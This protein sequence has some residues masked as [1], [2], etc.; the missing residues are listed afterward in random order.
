M[1]LFDIHNLNLNFQ[2]GW[3]GEDDDMEARLSGE[4]IGFERPSMKIA[5]FTMIK[6]ASRFKNPQRRKLL[7]QAKTRYQKDGLNSVE[8]KLK[9]IIDY[10]YYTHLFIDVGDPPEYILKLLNPKKIED[11]STTTYSNIQTPKYL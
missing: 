9:N 6:H 3:G 4:K 8:Y 7:K 2:K 10:K 1:T 5:R 11:N